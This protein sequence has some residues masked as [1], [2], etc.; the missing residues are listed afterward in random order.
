MITSRILAKS[1]NPIGIPIT[2]WLLRYPRF[3]HAEFMTHRDFSR[4]AAS[5]RA[6]PLK[7]TLASIR[8]NP[9]LPVW[10]GGHNKGMQ[11]GEQLVD[12]KLENVIADSEIAMQGCIQSAIRADK[13]GLHKSITNRWLEPWSHIT[14]VATI[15]DMRNFFA[16]RAH[17]AAQPEFQVLAYRMLDE[18]LAT[19]PRE[20]RWGQWHLPF[21]EAHDVTNLPIEDQLKVAT[22][23]CCWVSYNKPDKVLGEEANIEDAFMR[24]DESIKSGH[25]SPFEH[26]AQAINPDDFDEVYWKGDYP[27][28]NFDSQ[29]NMSGWG[30][31]RKHFREERKTTVDLEQILADRPEWTKTAGL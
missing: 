17:P 29:Y 31:Y 21:I 10:W 7:N 25:W 3:I 23:R 27:W 15:T 16:L 22:A 2:S 4:N 24:H 6:I 9:A 26:C 1:L 28:S 12:T 18:Y 11:S 14:V 8:D 20:L 5:S 19:K 30:Q 13:D